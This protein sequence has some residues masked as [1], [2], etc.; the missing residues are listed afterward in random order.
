MISIFPPLRL[1]RVWL[2]FG[3]FDAAAAQLSDPDVYNS[4]RISNN[5]KIADANG[6]YYINGESL[7]DS[8]GHIYTDPLGQEA[9]VLNLLFHYE[10]W[11]S[12][13]YGNVCRL[14]SSYTQPVSVIVESSKRTWST[15]EYSLAVPYQFINVLRNTNQTSSPHNF[16][17]FGAAYRQYADL[18]D[19]T[20]SFS[21]HHSMT[22]YSTGM[23]AVG[24]NYPYNRHR[25]FR[26]VD[27]SVPGM[28]KPAIQIDG[29]TSGPGDPMYDEVKTSNTSAAFLTFNLD[30]LATTT[31][32]GIEITYMYE[33]N[34]T[35]G[36]GAN[37]RFNTQCDYIASSRTAGT[38]GGSP[39]SAWYIQYAINQDSAAIPNYPNDSHLGWSLATSYPLHPTPSASGLDCDYACSHSLSMPWPSGYLDHGARTQNPPLNEFY[40]RLFLKSNTPAA[41]GGIDD[42]NPPTGWYR[43]TGTTTYNYWNGIKFVQ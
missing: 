38:S 1:K 33:M 6:Y 14:N 17:S 27:M 21:H 24:S 40:S 43:E 30:G 22:P 35:T 3:D 39:Q 10:S 29:R 37:G 28:V 31:F 20:T 9:L 18:H 34:G 26:V 7:L 42:G 4:N 36:N 12:D 16:S 13:P 11:I 25:G 8:S 19:T 5:L 41:A 15:C 32:N 2:N 23:M